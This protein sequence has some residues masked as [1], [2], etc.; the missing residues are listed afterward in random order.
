MRIVLRGFEESLFV[1]GSFSSELIGTFYTYFLRWFSAF[2]E[3]FVGSSARRH[4][5]LTNS[6]YSGGNACTQGS[7]GLL[8]F[9]AASSAPG[10]KS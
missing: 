10:N 8:F 2:S 6:A 9:N 1:R 7:G 4:G 3:P 5:V